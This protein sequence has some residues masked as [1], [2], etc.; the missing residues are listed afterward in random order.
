MVFPAKASA[1]RTGEDAMRAASAILLTLLHYKRQC[2]TVASVGDGD[3]IRVSEETDESLFA[4]HTSTRRNH[5]SD[6]GVQGQQR[7]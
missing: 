7:C 3:A 6:R 1:V 5:P 4:S 2:A